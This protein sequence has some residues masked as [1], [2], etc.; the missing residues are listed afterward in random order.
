MSIEG[1][2]ILSDLRA[3][4]GG[5]VKPPVRVQPL[6]AKG[7][8]DFRT[9]ASY[10]QVQIALAAAETFQ[11]PSPYFRRIDAVEGQKVQINGRWATN[12][13][14]Y[15]YLSLNT[16]DL[17]KDRVVAAV[18]DWGVSA[19]ASRLV[20]GNCAY[21]EALERGLAGFLG[22][23]AALVMVS[24]H[25]TN[26]SILRTLVGPGDLIAVD[27]LAHNSIYE[28]VRLSGAAHVTFPHNDFGWLDR[29]LET[30]RDQFNRVIVVIEGLYSMDGD[31]PDLAEFVRLKQRHDAWLMVDEAHSIGVLGAS[32][33]GIAEEQGVDPAAI[34]IVMGTLSKTFCSAGGFVAGTRDLIDVLKYNAP[35][36]VYSVGLSAP[37][38][39]AALAALEEL[40]R[41]PAR[42]AR[43]RR[44]GQ[45]FL[46]AARSSGLDCG[47]NQGFAIAPVI[48]GDSILATRLSAQLLDSGF[49]VLPIIA[50][51]VPEKSARLRFFLNAGHDVDAIDAVI[52]KTA[53]LS[54]R[55]RLSK[56]V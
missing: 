17:L 53:E 24:G 32:G 26:Q 20:G 56:A 14:G 21:H 52:A 23:E 9:L 30:N 37:N 31:C 33:R 19:R 44:L 13:A 51:A 55:L 48:V 49:N 39:A 2:K 10:R 38:T 29:H 3:L 16:S 28:G 22:T 42:T 12:F 4:H 27:A 54:G 1:S 36:F 43:L 50:P 35:G 11:L 46:K 7:R 15:D 45:H 8:A 18:R 34:D 25:G 47:P 41:S 40:Q 6:P 5:A